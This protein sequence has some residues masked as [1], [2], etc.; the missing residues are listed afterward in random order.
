MPAQDILEPKELQTGL[1]LF[2]FRKKQK[3]SI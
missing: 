3:A 2:G 1:T